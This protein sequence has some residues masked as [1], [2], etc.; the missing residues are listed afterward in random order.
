MNKSKFIQLLRTLNRQELM[1]FEKYHRALYPGYIENLKVFNYIKRHVPDFDSE[2]LEKQIAFKNIFKKE[3]F[4]YRKIT[5]ALSDL[6]LIL[7]EFL[8]WQVIRSDGFKRD[9]TFAGILK[10]RG[11][12]NEFFNETEKAKKKITDR[13]KMGSWDYLYLLQL[14]YDAFYNVKSNKLNSGI[15][16]L[17]SS[18]INLDK[19]FLLMKLKIGAE[20][21]AREHIL[22]EN[23][24]IFLLEEILNL[25]GNEQFNQEI[26]IQIYCALLEMIRSKDVQSFKKFKNQ[27]ISNLHRIDDVETQIILLYLINFSAQKIREGNSKFYEEAFELYQLGLETGSLFE[28]GNF[29]PTRFINIVDIACK[30]EKYNWAEQ[31][32]REREMLLPVDSKK[33][34]VNMSLARIAFTRKEFGLTINILSKTIFKD[35]QFSNRAKA[36]IIRSYYELGEEINLILDFGLAFEKSLRR[37]KTLNPNVKNGYFNLIKMIRHLVKG[38][39]SKEQLL[40]EFHKLKEL[41][42]SDWVKA[43]IETQ[44]G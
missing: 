24:E 12:H 41:S 26:L 35:I 3:A 32:I 30:L 18:M 8:L 40:S 20:M 11:L 27:F 7:K 33:D 42:C 1:E 22:N 16:S 23:N 43:K 2:R 15:D 39:K 25:A 44:T 29:T 36:L 13:K 17:N 5:D 9:H 28:K 4:N 19:L 21:K 10:H 6:Y 38:T 14:N 34:T 31:F 37:N